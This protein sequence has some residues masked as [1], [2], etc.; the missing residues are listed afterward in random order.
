MQMFVG[1]VQAFRNPPAHDLN[2][3]SAKDAVEMIAIFSFLAKRLDRAKKR[4]RKKP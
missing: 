3:I 1:A 2:P 4:K